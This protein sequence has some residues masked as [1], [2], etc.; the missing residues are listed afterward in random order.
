[1]LEPEPVSAPAS[2][3]AL[4]PGIAA[5]L[6]VHGLVRDLRPELERL[7]QVVGRI[8][9]VDNNEHACTELQPLQHSPL[10]LT[11]LQGGNVGGLAG[12]YNRALQSLNA[13]PVPPREVVF[14][15]QDSDSAVLARFLADAQVQALLARND[16]A[17]VAPAYRDRATGLRARYIE[18]GRWRAQHM[19]REFE[20]ARP[21]AFIINS[22]S[23][24][25]CAAL[26]QLGPF[27]ETLAIDHVDTEHCLR[28]RRQ[29]LGIWVH[30]SHEFAHAIGQRRRYRLFGRDL[31]AT[32][33]GPARRLLIARNTLLLARRWGWREPGFA[34]L[35]LGRLAYEAVGILVAE[36]QAATKLAALLRGALAGLFTHRAP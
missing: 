28:A 10:P 4:H 32:G 7:A 2:A 9:L 1:M 20:G 18:L 27:D 30:G 25:R 13:G 8:V 29:G 21:V 33:H 26:E 12:A 16:V 22:M 23:V 15:D 14:I 3:I 34:W 11:L 5:V 31:Q 19:Q 6:V 36:P 35:C 17:A 24:W